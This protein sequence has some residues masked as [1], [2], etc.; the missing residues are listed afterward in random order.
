MTREEA[1]QY[2]IDTGI[3]PEHTMEI[4]EA[5]EQEPCEE[6]DFVQPHKKISVNLEVCKMREATQEERDGVDQYIDSI[7][8]ECEDCVSRNSIIEV[9]NKMDRYVANELTLCDTGKKFPKNEVFIVDDV[10]DE[11][12]EQ[13]P[14]V[15]PKQKTGRWVVKGEIFICSECGEISCCKGK[16]CNECGSKNMEVGG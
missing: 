13:L 8:E 6:L 14:S 10:Y 16:Y 12:T 1:I 3:S 7:A 5:I 11:I 2:L 15:Y 9:L 4:I